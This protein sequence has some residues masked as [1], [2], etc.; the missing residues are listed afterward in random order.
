MSDDTRTEGQKW[1]DNV[2]GGRPHL[3]HDDHLVEL[4]DR[5]AQELAK[6]SAKGITLSGLGDHYPVALLEALCLDAE[7]LGEARR[8]HEEWARDIIDGAESKLSLARLLQPGRMD[9]R[10]NGGM[11]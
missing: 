3:L 8:R 4:I 2:T 10:Q 1:A 6:L 9:P 11:G 7:I 5:N